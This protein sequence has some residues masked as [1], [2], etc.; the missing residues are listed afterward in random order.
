MATATSSLPTLSGLRQTIS[1]TPFSSLPKTGEVGTLLCSRIV[2]SFARGL[3]TRDWP[4]LVR[5]PYRQDATFRGRNDERA[6]KR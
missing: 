2:M 4:G 1:S 6:G 3:M 5:G